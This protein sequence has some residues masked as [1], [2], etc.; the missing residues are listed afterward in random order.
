[1]T[2]APQQAHSFSQDAQEGTT[3][4]TPPRIFLRPIGTPIPLGFMALSAVTSVLAVVQLHWIPVTQ[5]QTAAWMALVVAAPLQLM[6]SVFG[7]WARDPI[8]GSGMAFLAGTWALIGISTL[9][10][11]PGSTSPGLGV[12]LLAAAA[13]LLVPACSS[14]GKRV[15]AG[16][17]ALAA[18]R[19]AVTGIYELTAASGWR[20]AAGAV[21]LALGVAA[22]YG[23]FAFELEGAHHKRVLPVGRSRDVTRN[24]EPGVRRRL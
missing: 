1:M 3:P 19:F 24:G 9:L 20:V 5:G 23:A 8:A 15:A 7:Y 22:L 12:A 18:A 16:V 10:S 2:A 17:I 21:G 11:P 6:A 4:D 13:A 14:A